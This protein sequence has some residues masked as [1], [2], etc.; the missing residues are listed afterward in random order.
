MSLPSHVD[1]EYL[2]PMV[3][4]VFVIVTLPSHVDFVIYLDFEWTNDLGGFSLKV[5]LLFL[6]VHKWRSSS[7]PVAVAVLLFSISLMYL[8]FR[9]KL[10]LTRALL[11]KRAG[12]VIRFP[13]DWRRS[14]FPKIKEHNYVKKTCLQVLAFQKNW[15][16]LSPIIVCILAHCMLPF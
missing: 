5:V 16:S 7:V 13:P 11:R 4:R 2:V 10:N 14:L 15:R 12:L 1:L 6:R 9:I 8:L 3:P